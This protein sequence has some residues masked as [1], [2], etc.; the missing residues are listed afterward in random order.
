MSPVLND[1]HGWVAQSLSV[2]YKTLS[3]VSV[4]ITGGRDAARLGLIIV[5]AG[6]N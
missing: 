6:C 1:A 3:F 2:R 4:A 5:S